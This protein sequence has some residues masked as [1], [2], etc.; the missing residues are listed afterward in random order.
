MSRLQGGV[1]RAATLVAAGG[2]LELVC[3]GFGAVTGGLTGLTLGWLLALGVEAAVMIPAV[4][5]AATAPVS[6]AGR[7][8]SGGDVQARSRMEAA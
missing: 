8:L 5:A 2:V 6:P 3:A 1:V 7:L 4:Y